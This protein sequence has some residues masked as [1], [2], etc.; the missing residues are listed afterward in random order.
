[1]MSQHLQLISGCQLPVVAAVA[2]VEVAV[3]AVAVVVVLAETENFAN[4][5]RIFSAFLVINDVSS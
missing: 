4:S 1:M 2:A 3:L 5:V